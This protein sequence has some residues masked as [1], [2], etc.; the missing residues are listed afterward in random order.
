[1]NADVKARWLAALRSGEYQQGQNQ[2]RDSE[3]HFCC[4]GVLC[5]VVDPDGW[6]DTEGAG[7]EVAHLGEVLTPDRGLREGVGLDPI[8]EQALVDMNDDLE[9]D[10][11]E[12]ADWI[13]ENL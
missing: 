5:D 2:L 12:I 1:M 3:D 11:C 10:F 8:Q 13:E 4:L 9:Y 7:D 6:D